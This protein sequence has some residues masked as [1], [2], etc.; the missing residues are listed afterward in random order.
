MDFFNIHTQLHIIID[1][2]VKFQGNHL[3]VGGGRQ[4]TMNTICKTNENGHN[5]N[6]IFH[7]QLY[8]IIDALSCNKIIFKN[9]RRN[10]STIIM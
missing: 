4:I 1:A 3:K 10:Y 5:E 8:I 6:S 2:L 9:C 7:A